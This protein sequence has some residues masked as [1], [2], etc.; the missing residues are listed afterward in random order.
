MKQNNQ[1][2]RIEQFIE[3]IQT[4]EADGAV[5]LLDS[6]L[7]SVG[8]A[9]TLG[10]SNGKHCNNY[11]AGSCGSNKSYCTNYDGACLNSQ[12]GSFCFNQKKDATNQVYP[13]G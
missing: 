11:Q 1:L 9:D 6:E 5:I 2:A 4:S 12:N 8:S 10:Y 3:K 7:D 13:C